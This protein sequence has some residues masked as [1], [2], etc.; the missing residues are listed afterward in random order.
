[1]LRM[2]IL[3]AYYLGSILPSTFHFK[4]FAAPPT[5]HPAPFCTFPTHMLNQAII[6]WP[7]NQSFHITKKV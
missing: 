7:H 1:R 2:N 5:R 6:E 3:A 4:E